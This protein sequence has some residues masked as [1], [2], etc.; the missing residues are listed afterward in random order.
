VAVELVRTV[1]D[2]DREILADTLLMRARSGSAPR[3]PPIASLTYAADEEWILEGDALVAQTGRTASDT[4]DRPAPGVELYRLL[5]TMNLSQLPW[6]EKVDHDR[7]ADAIVCAPVRSAGIAG[8]PWLAALT[9]Q[10][11]DRPPTETA[12]HVMLSVDDIAA[13]DRAGACF[14]RD[15]VIAV[16]RAAA[17]PAAVIFGDASTADAASAAL[18]RY[19]RAALVHAWQSALAGDAQDDVT[20]DRDAAAAELLSAL[21]ALL[22]DD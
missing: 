18:H 10:A 6:G 20:R 11:I 19:R 22:G 13:V 16:A 1:S 7:L 8:P 2:A 12:L 21:R 9:T 4:P 3:K 15:A 5:S 14:P 17:L